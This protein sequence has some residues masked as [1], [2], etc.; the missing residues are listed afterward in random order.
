M[1]RLPDDDQGGAVPGVREQLR[2]HYE[3]T[4]DL[5]R[6]ATAAGTDRATAVAEIIRRSQALHD[7]T[8]WAAG[9]A[10]AGLFEP[11]VAVGEVMLDADPPFPEATDN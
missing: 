3:W 5:Y 11:D 8:V 9:D 2:Q 7:V 1:N 10:D 4:Q 6:Q